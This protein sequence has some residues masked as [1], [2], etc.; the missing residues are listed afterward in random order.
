MIGY[1]RGGTTS[2][3]VVRHCASDVV[4][5]RSVNAPLASLCSQTK[6][7]KKKEDFA[8]LL[9]FARCLHYSLYFRRFQQSVGLPQYSSTREYSTRKIYRVIVKFYFW[10]RGP[11]PPN[12]GNQNLTS[13]PRQHYNRYFTALYRRPVGVATHWHPVR[14]HYAHIHRGATFPKLGNPKFKFK[15]EAKPHQTPNK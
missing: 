12:W 7:W 10:H 1:I 6:I 4:L 15:I 5:V 3:G 2:Y 13:K 11:V 8:T 9:S 14:H